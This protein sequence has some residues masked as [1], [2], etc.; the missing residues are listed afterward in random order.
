MAIYQNVGVIGA[1][2]LGHALALVHAIGGCDVILHDISQERLD[3]AQGRLPE[4]LDE[5]I[6]YELIDVDA[7]KA[8]LARLRYT[9]DI[10][11]AVKSADLV[12]EAII[13]NEDAKR[14]LFKTLEPML[15]KNTVLASNTSFL[16]I[17]PLV[18]DALR[19]RTLIVHWYTPPYLIDL[20]DVVPSEEAS[21][22]LAKEMVE[23]LR[24]IGKKPVLLKKFVPGYV[25]NNI[26]MAIES[27][28]F[29]LL[30]LGVADVADIDDALRFGL[31]QRLSIMGQ[32]KKIDFTGLEVVRDIHANGLY[33][34][35][36]KPT[37]TPVLDQKLRSGGNGVMSGNGFY[38]YGVTPAPELFQ[39]RD[40][41]L[42]KLKLLISEF[43][44]DL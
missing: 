22:Q 18:P 26:Q 40:A 35:P 8:T 34:P 6:E 43:D 25:A 12:V 21:P 23:F 4:L 11:V 20:V 2:L 14:T 33:T 28:I 24:D 42:A 31:A 13:E 32:F 7:A 29:R 3:W 27:E 16:N 10:D 44:D 1:G 15:G 19:A 37:G 38:D 39:R 41:K 30:D 17:F 36:S 5:L 9:S